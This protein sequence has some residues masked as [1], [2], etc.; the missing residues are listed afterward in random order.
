MKAN[1]PWAVALLAA[2]GTMPALAC[3]TV[4]DRNNNVVYNAKTPPVDMSQPL[5]ETLQ[6]AYPGG[7]L[8]FG[9]DASCPEENTAG[10]T[11]LASPRGKAPLLTDAATAQELGLPHTMIRNVAVVP[12]TPDSLRAQVMV[13]ES[14][15]GAP[16]DAN[17]TRSMGAGPSNTR[18][19]GAGPA[20]QAQQRMRGNTV[21]T[22]MRE[23]PV[24]VQRGR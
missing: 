23:P 15:P 19:M 11:R 2:A 7:H 8:V 21:I 20:P 17:D 22:E 6:K 18:A 5:H 13:V 12:E 16:A 3:F 14:L 9:N 10:R 1:L 24:P 4:Y